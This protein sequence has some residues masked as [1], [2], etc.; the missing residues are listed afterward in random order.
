MDFEYTAT[1]H[2]SKEDLRKM[3]L[4]VYWGG[5]FCDI[6]DEII[7]GYDDKIY[8]SSEYIYDQ[9]QDEILRRLKQSE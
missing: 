5:D 6:F 8:Y 1:I 4:Y 7:S 3:Y 2:I 9:V